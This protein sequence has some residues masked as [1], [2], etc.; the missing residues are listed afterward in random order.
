MTDWGP[1]CIGSHY[2]VRT[3]ALREIGGIGLEL[4]EDCTTSFLITTAGW[5]GAFAMDAEAHGDGP[6]TFAAML[7]QEFQWSRSLTMVLLGLVP[8]NLRP[9]PWR[10]KLRL[11]VRLTFY[12]AAGHLHGRLA[13]CWPSPRR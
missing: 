3:E 12:G 13:S 11:H 2:A 9:L 4:A 6:N 5:H 7:V 10:L 8:R 1:L